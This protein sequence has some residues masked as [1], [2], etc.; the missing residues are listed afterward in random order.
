MTNNNLKIHAPVR[1]LV[2]SLLPTVIIGWYLFDKIITEN[3]QKILMII[4]ALLIQ[5]VIIFV[6][7]KT[8][9]TRYPFFWGVYNFLTGNGKLPLKLFASSVILIVVLGLCFDFFGL[10]QNEIYTSFIIRFVELDLYWAILNFL[11]ISD[12]SI[13]AY[14]F[15]RFL[16]LLTAFCGVIFW[17][18][19]ISI[20]VIKFSKILEM[21]K[22][23]PSTEELDEL[24]YNESNEAFTKKGSSLFI[25]IK[26]NDNSTFKSRIS[27]IKNDN[28]FKRFS[29]KNQK[30]TLIS[31]MGFF[32]IVLFIVN[33][34][35]FYQ[36]R[37]NKRR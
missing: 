33:L 6:S 18:M 5:A 16:T 10:Q 35:L 37:K 25:D 32:G 19:Y 14:G 36:E 31:I 2:V 24:L 1:T 30:N 4:G 23:K 22:T 28:I 17:G 13:T 21:K 8:R 26:E 9:N 34:L 15:S 20:I 11:G 3:Y 7:T 27:T 29:N 12:P